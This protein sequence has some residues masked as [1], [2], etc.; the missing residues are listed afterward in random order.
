MNIW[1]A[2]RVQ[3]KKTANFSVK[4]WR[5]MAHKFKENGYLDQEYFSIESLNGQAWG[6]GLCETRWWFMVQKTSLN[7]K[8]GSSS[9]G[10]SKKWS[11]RNWVG[12]Y[13]RLLVNRLPFSIYLDH[14]EC[15]MVLN[16][17]LGLHFFSEGPLVTLAGWTTIPSSNLTKFSVP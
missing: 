7:S 6:G 10:Q 14:L 11:L 16:H 13:R 1:D 9:F 2:Y 15:P 3:P 17:L 8:R 5:L 12:A 4:Q